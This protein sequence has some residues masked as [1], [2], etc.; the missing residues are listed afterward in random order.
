M[1]VLFWSEEVRRAQ[2]KVVA[3]RCT[4]AAMALMMV[5]GAWSLVGTA[6][7]KSIDTWVHLPSEFAVIAIP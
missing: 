3:R 2:R 6:T 7:I 5:I 4:V 1:D